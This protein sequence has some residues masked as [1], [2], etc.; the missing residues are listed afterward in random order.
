MSLI[1]ILGI[2]SFYAAFFGAI[3]IE[4]EWVMKDYK[5]QYVRDQGF[6]GGPLFKYEL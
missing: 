5:I 2:I 3:T 4:R 1:G 6:S